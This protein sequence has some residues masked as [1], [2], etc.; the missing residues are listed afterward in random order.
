M[1]GSAVFDGG[2]FKLFDGVGSGALPGLVK[3]VGAGG[4]V[5]RTPW[6]LSLY[7]CSSKVLKRPESTGAFPVSV[8]LGAYRAGNGKRGFEAMF[9]RRA[10]GAAEAE[11][12]TPENPAF[13]APAVPEIAFTINEGERGPSL[14]LLGRK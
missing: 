9:Q 6:D 10:R 2:L 5:P 3:A 14:V 1:S 7:A 8:S 4:P 11:L 12:R 13:V